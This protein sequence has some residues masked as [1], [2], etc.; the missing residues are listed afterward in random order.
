MYY[1]LTTGEENVFSPTEKI[2]RPNPDNREK[3]PLGRNEY[4]VD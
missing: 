3:N 1:N 2:D 4:H